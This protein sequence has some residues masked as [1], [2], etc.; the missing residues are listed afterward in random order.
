[1][2]CIHKLSC[3]KVKH[4]TSDIIK[5]LYML[6][7][8]TTMFQHSVSYNFTNVKTW[9][10]YSTGTAAGTTI[11]ASAKKAVPPSIGIALMNT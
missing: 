2:L 9:E 11:L 1:M 4:H 6:Y 8:S 10:I 7:T 3:Y 5:V